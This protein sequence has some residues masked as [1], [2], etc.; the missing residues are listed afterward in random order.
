MALK[1]LG[2]PHS[3]R[4]ARVA[5]QAFLMKTRTKHKIKVVAGRIAIVPITAFTLANI[6]GMHELTPVHVNNKAGLALENPSFL[7]V[8][9]SLVF[10][11]PP[12]PSKTTVKKVDISDLSWGTS[13][14][15][16]GHVMLE[17]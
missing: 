7:V 1:R 17:G 12:V 15:L 2:E 11:K 13:G 8:S 3:G 9:D 4:S 10:I 14:T 16:W 6:V 5:P